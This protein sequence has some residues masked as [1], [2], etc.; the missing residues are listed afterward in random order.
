MPQMT[1]LYAHFRGYRV[2]CHC[3][4]GVGIRSL[5][6]PY[7]P[8][9]GLNT[10]KEFASLRIQSNCWKIR[11]RKTPNMGTVHAVC[12]STCASVHY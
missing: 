4:E 10:K 9:F 2:S 7:F 6:G 1:H 3:M 12:V 8:T 5:T 11:I